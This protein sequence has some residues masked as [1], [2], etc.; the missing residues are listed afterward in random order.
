MTSDG[1][2]ARRLAALQRLAT[3]TPANRPLE[4]ALTSGLDTATSSGLGIPAAAALVPHDEHESVIA[5]SGARNDEGFGTLVDRVAAC[6]ANGCVQSEHGCDIA[7]HDAVLPNGDPS[8]ATAMVA[9]VPVALCMPLRSG[10]AR[11]RGNLLV[12]LE[13]TDPLDADGRAFVT[14]LKDHL[15]RSV[16]TVRAI[17]RAEEG[18]AEEVAAAHSKI[19]HLER[20]LESNRLIGTAVGILMAELRITSEEAFDRLRTA[21]QT[22]NRKLSDVADDVV[23]TGAL[24]ASPQAGQRSA[25]ESIAFGGVSSI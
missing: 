12:E 9:I 22:S 7:S 15:A 17:G 1:Q 18:A 8:R 3:L 6:M 10:G 24:P 21:S 13:G 2:Q 19:E 4:A 11:R 23:F 14:T 25:G 20:A 5:L 16:D